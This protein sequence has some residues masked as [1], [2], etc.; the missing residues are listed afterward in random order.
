MESQTTND[1]IQKTIF[2]NENGIFAEVG[3]K[4]KNEK[5]ERKPRKSVEKKKTTCS[6]GKEVLESNLDKHKISKYHIK[7]STPTPN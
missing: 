5:K 4:M 2:A 7:H 6:C 3:M 1:Q